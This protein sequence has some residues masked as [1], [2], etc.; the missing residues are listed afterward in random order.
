MP[1][2]DA[3]PVVIEAA[4]LCGVTATIVQT[5]ISRDGLDVAE[6]SELIERARVHH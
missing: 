3:L 1:T 6:L 4:E 2:T 5:W